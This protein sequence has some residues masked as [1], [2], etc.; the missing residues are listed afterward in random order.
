MVNIWISNNTGRVI[1]RLN[2]EATEGYYKIAEPSF[3]PKGV[4]CRPWTSKYR[5]NA[6]ASRKTSGQEQ[7]NYDRDYD[8]YDG[9]SQGYNDNNHSYQGRNDYNRNNANRDYY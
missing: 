2:V 3:W 9:Y 4:K 8:G 7:R 5:Y 1:I 6:S